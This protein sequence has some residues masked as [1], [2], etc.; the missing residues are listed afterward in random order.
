[1]K[2]PIADYSLLTNEKRASG[3]GATKNEFEKCQMSEV[4][5]QVSPQISLV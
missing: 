5:L 3:Y 2:L 4:P 1:M